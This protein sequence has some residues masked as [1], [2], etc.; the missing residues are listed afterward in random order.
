MTLR[1]S[2]ATLAFVALLVLG[3]GDFERGNR[4]YRAGRYEQAVEAY[5]AAL[6]D[7]DDRAELRYNLGTALLRLGRYEEAQQFLEAALEDVE[8][9]LRQRTL[10]NLG[11]RVLE[12]GRASAEPE[13]RNRLLDAAIDAYKDALR[14][15]PSDQDA[16]WNLELALRDQEQPPEEDPQDDQD[17]QDQ[18][19]QDQGGGG[20]APSPNAPQGDEPNGG[21]DTPAPLTPQ[22]AEQIMN[23][24]EQDERELYQEQLR[25]GARE[26]PVARDW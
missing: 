14:L 20:E 21:G 9:A 8:P 25:R 12:E 18:R 2:V 16:K 5:R 7:G 17:Q 22:Q 6:E 3:I 10:Y 19:D 23:A 13:Q 4:H 1:E 15:D 11:N 24:V 26:T